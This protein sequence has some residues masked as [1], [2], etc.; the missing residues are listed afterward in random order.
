MK[1][2]H[3]CNNLGS[4]GAEKLLTD[5]LPFFNKA[6]IDVT[7][8]VCNKDK[9]FPPFETKMQNSGVRYISFSRGFY[10]PLLVWSIAKQIRREKYAIV[11]AHSFPDT[12]LACVGVIVLFTTSSHGSDRALRSQ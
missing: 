6:G 7:F 3:I 5:I 8:A 12:I 2:L 11:H 4:G 10:S 9:N 1:I